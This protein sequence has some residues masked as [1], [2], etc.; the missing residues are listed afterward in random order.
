M[1]QLPKGSIDL[2]QNEKDVIDYNLKHG[3]KIAYVTQ[4]T[5]S[6]DDTKDIIKALKNKY[7]DLKRAF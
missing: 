2:I 5:L 3:K 6:V 1:G 4:T 7:S